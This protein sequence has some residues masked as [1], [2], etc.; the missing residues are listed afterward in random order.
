MRRNGF[1]I[2][3]ITSNGDFQSSKLH[4]GLSHL[5]LLS[6]RVVCLNYLNQVPLV[7]TIL[8]VTAFQSGHSATKKFAEVSLVYIEFFPP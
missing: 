8:A 4:S 3:C 6:Q 7:E 1:L 5:C 2:Y